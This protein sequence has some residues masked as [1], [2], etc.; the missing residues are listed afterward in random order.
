MHSFPRA[1]AE[2]PVGQPG[3]V[4]RLSLPALIILGTLIGPGHAGKDIYKVLERLLTQICGGLAIPNH[5]GTSNE[6]KRNKA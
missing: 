1:D 4:T 6:W 2:S 3:N 5:A